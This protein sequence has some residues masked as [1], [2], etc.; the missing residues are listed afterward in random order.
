M[1]S[2]VPEKG[3]TK[4][5]TPRRP[6]KRSPKEAPKPAP[7]TVD[8]PEKVITT[9]E[10]IRD[11]YLPRI[12][13]FT[14]A[15]APEDITFK[16]G[17]PDDMQVFD[18]QGTVTGIVLGY[19]TT[20]GTIVLN[21]D[22]TVG[23][24][25]DQLTGLI[26]HESTH[27][28]LRDI[29]LG[30]NPSAKMFVEGLADYV[31]DALVPNS[32]GDNRS[33][34][35]DP[36]AKGYQGAAAFF[37]FVEEKYPGAI[38]ATIGGLL[39]G[40]ATALDEITGKA[41]PNLIAR[42]KKATTDTEFTNQ[43]LDKE[44]DQAWRQVKQGNMSYRQYGQTVGQG[45]RNLGDVTPGLVPTPPH[46]APH[47]ASGPNPG[48][49][50]IYD[51]V[52]PTFSP[53]D[54]LLATGDILGFD[55][56]PPVFDPGPPPGDGGSGGSSGGSSSGSSS[57]SS[58]S[59]SAA[60]YDQY[61]SD[62]FRTDAVSRTKAQMFA[63]AYEQLWGEPATENYLIEAVKSGMNTQE[64]VDRER[65]KESFKKTKTFEDEFRGGFDLLRGMGAV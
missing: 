19:A 8:T 1:P 62:I 40:D 47:Y 4:E 45:F 52:N 16:F 38:K 29:N 59:S 33:Q 49:S 6:A 56:A 55:E 13:A 42:F 11:V 31:R 32:G 25:V 63:S 15:P 21:P 17:K 23:M 54:G 46:L 9:A 48:I 44:L 36:V 34:A 35:D 65:M 3:G 64:F 50:A 18:Q 2:T 14:G 37:Q 10:H 30:D 39:N 53:L 57:S 58:S 12:S 20:D 22:A 51:Q 43:D 61:I 24:T 5:T 60:K 27:E 41:T 7:S 26:V 28:A